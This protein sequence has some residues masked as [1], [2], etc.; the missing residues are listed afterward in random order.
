[1]RQLTLSLVLGAL[2]LLVVSQA[3]PSA[4]SKVR[5]EGRWSRTTTCQE[6]VAAL[7][8]SGLRA[9]APAV[10]AGNGLVP[11]SAAQ[12]AAK[13]K[14]CSGATPRVHSHFFNSHGQFGS[15]DWTGKQVDDGSYRVIGNTVHIGDGTFAFRIVDDVLTLT[16][17]ITAAAKHQALAHPGQ[18]SSAGWQVAVAYPGHTWKRV[19]CKGWC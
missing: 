15:V 8:K 18:F 13:P 14:I 10:L 11:G 9:L 16:P 17:V 1:L 12:I 7:Q 3:A 5:L 19:P 6:M 2:L 4:P